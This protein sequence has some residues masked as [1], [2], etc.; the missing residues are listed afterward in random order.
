MYWFCD[1]WYYSFRELEYIEISL[2]IEGVKEEGI[3]QRIYVGSIILYSFDDDI[4]NR[5]EDEF[6]EKVDE[7]YY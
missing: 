1:G 5:D 3:Q 2:E 6:Y 7:V 4:V